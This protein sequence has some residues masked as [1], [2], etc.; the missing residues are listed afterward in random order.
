VLSWLQLSCRESAGTVGLCAPV[1]LDLAVHL[2][3]VMVFLQMFQTFIFYFAFCLELLPKFFTV[4]ACF[5]SF[6]CSGFSTFDK[7]QHV[8]SRA[9]SSHVGDGF[10]QFNIVLQMASNNHMSTTC[11]FA[12]HVS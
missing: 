1:S 2:L 11:C 3:H 9:A 6:M 8:F 5:G 10:L 12:R 4:L 7:Y